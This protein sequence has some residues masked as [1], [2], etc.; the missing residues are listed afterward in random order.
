MFKYQW[1]CIWTLYWSANFVFHLKTRC[2]K[3]DFWMSSGPQ[4]RVCKWKLF[5]LFLNQNICCGY[6]KEPS[7]WDGSFEHPK[8]MFQL[9]D[10]KIIAIYAN[11]FSL[12]GPLALCP[13]TVASTPGPSLH[14]WERG[15][16]LWMVFLLKFGT[17]LR[18]RYVGLFLKPTALFAVNTAYVNMKKLKTINLLFRTLQVYSL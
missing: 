12:T 10:K 7:R 3:Q 1:K 13:K 2:Y 16:G 18:L 6:S 17:V 15:Q 14:F 4:K 5:F 8:H 9:M 11:Y